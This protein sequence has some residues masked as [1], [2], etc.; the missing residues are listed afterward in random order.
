[1]LAEVNNVSSEDAV[2]LIGILLVVCCLIGAGYMAY[3]Q[4]ALACGLLI[5]VA[6]VA[7]FLLL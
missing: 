5:V 4:N 6:I 3:L 7:A 1:M 2:T